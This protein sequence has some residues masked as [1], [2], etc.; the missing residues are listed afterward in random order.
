MAI[1]MVTRNYKMC[2]RNGNFSLGGFS[3][4]TLQL[5]WSEHIG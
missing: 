1:A 4:P 5:D 2:A 3:F